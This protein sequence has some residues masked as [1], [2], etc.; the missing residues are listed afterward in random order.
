M[1]D[2]TY[3][4]SRSSTGAGCLRA[5]LSRAE[6]TAWPRAHVLPEQL[7]ESER[8]CPWVPKALGGQCCIL[9]VCVSW[10]CTLSPD[11]RERPCRVNGARGETHR[12]WP[13]AGGVLPG[14]RPSA[15]GERSPCQGEGWSGAGRQLCSA[16][17]CPRGSRCSRVLFSDRSEE[18][19]VGKECLRLCRS[20][21]SPY[22]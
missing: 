17:P 2:K 4:K 19:R 1:L 14:V 18:R 7:P 21:W 13:A 15:R 22:H 20:R 12:E 16:W 11:S 3:R 5:A 10:P 9:R 8:R 6:R